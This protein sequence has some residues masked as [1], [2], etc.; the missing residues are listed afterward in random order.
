MDEHASF[1][2]TTLP[3]VFTCQL[4]LHMTYL[5]TLHLLSLFYIVLS[6]LIY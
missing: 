3:V 6:I 4:A 1:A 2:V 5:S